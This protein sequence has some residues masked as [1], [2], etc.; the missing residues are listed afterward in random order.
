MLQLKGKITENTERGND[1]KQKWTRA[2][3][4]F[5]LCCLLVGILP[6]RASAASFRD[7]P[8]GHWAGSSISRCADLGLFQGK[9]AS[10]FGLGQSMTRCA[11]VVV[12]DRFFGW[13]D[14]EFALPYEDVPADAWYAGALRSAYANGAVTGQSR[15]F[16][17]ADPVTREELA[18]MLVR[19]LGYPEIAGVAQDLPET[20]TD[21]SSNPGYIAMARDLGLVSGVRAD[22]FAPD[23]YATREQVAVILMRLY[24]KLYSRKGTVM[25]IVSSGEEVRGL[26]IAAA[27]A[28][29]ITGSGVVREKLGAEQLA[30]VRTAAEDA[31]AA[32]VL[33]ASGGGSFLDKEAGAVA[34]GLAAVVENGAYEGLLVE[35]KS[36]STKQ[37]GKLTEFVTALRGRLGQR[38]L[39]L[40]LPAPARET[41]DGLHDYAALARTADGLVLR[42]EQTVKMADTFPVAP[43]EPLEEVYWS[44][45]HLRSC[46]ADMANMS[47]ML[48]TEGVRFS[49][50]QARERLTGQEVLAL[51]ESREWQAGY[52]ERYGC[53]YLEKEGTNEAVW[54][55]NGR[56]AAD[57]IRMLQ[58]FGASGVC[59]ESPDAASE[60]LLMAIG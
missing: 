47:L 9:T 55:L 5:L 18:V 15:A 20:F 36:M 45:S 43:L 3:S 19:A 1:M 30:A 23:K 38:E 14:V 29:M 39:Y 24:D 59:L 50:A 22:T 35:V 27:D 56:A 48:S 28:A 31:G 17:P 4:S 21:V 2:W 37:Q 8:A 57:R 11:A 46:G 41:K 26:D 25:G 42:V 40:V 53:A 60:E 10:A 12:L 58:L 33:Y 51:A 6:G 16:R 13:E 34:E 49:G 54:Y 52:S 44:L 7:V 32:V